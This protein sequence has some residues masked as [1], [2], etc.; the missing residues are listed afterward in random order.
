MNAKNLSLLAFLTLVVIITAVVLTRPKTTTVPTTKFFP[1]LQTSALNEVT[2]INI[3]TQDENI[4]LMLSDKQWGLKEKHHYPVA[5]EKVHN[6]L[7]GLAG[8]TILEAKTSNPALYSKIGVEAVTEEGAKST[9]LTLKNAQGETVASVI[10]GNDRTAKI[11]STRQ[12]I[13]L[14]KPDEKQTW[15]TLGRLPVE[16]T[17]GDWLEEEIVDIDGDNVRQISIT[18][19]D[20]ES[21]L[22][23]K[24]TPE[25]KDYQIADLPD[26]ASIK[27]PYT[28]RSLAGTLSHLNL[29]DSVPASDIKFA[30]QKTHRAVFSTFDGLEITL[31]T[32]KKDDKHYAQLS[33]AFNPEMVWVEPPKSDEALPKDSIHQS[34]AAHDEMKDEPEVDIKQQA[35]TL[36]AKF[37]GWVYELAAYKVD[38]LEKKREDLIEV[39][40]PAAQEP[41]GDIDIEGLEDLPLSMPEFNMPKLNMP[42]LDSIPT[43]LFEEDGAEE[44]LSTPFSF[45]NVQ[46]EKPE[47]LPTPLGT[48]TTT[49]ETMIPV[50]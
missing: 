2:E 33:A 43:K 40:E 13:Y 26:N 49:N 8:L 3:T 18:H 47:A 15:L 50:P 30:K 44:A 28:L 11:D 48:P 7:F 6:L 35:E 10:I 25:N 23:S 1:N 12:E 5:V 29:D 39:E 21:L 14:R 9:L 45:S 38:D 17:V 42:E 37:K 4:T 36:N 27:S 22:I 20:G 46:V 31:F 41:I 19:P 16:K 34:V 32:M 24:A